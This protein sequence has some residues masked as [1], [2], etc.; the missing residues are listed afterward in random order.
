MELP[1]AAS[2]RVSVDATLAADGKLTAKVKY[3]M[4]GDN[5]LLLRLAFH[6]APREKWSEVAQLLSLSDGFR[7]KITSVSASDPFA[8]HEPF[9]VEYEISQTKFVDWS[10]KPVRIP[11]ILPLVGL[12]DPPAAANAAIEL[13]TPLEVE[14]RSTLR[15][16]A[17]FVAQAPTGT[18]VARDYAAFSS[19]YAASGDGASQK[20]AMLTASR[21]IRFL[22]RQIPGERG[23]DY[24]T[25]LRAVQN[26]EAQR[27]VITGEAAEKGTPAAAPVTGKNAPAKP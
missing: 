1:F 17:G 20:N 14:T 24:R 27:F 21:D 10:K 5:E 25:F 4:R 19:K 12:P 2:Q 9:T 22:A 26:D 18:A 3:V 13:G 16:P 11:A 23:G 7:G 6:Q 15:L 8:T